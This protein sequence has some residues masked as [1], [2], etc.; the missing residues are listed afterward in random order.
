MEQPKHEIADILRG[1]FHRLGHLSKRTRQ[2]VHNIIACRTEI[3][4]GH[5]YECDDPDC[6][7]S[8]H[9]YNSC[10]DRHCP[11][12]QYAARQEW[13]KARMSEVLP[14]PY[15]HFV[16]TLPHVFNILILTNKVVI[17]NLFFKTASNVVKQL[18]A[19]EYE[20]AKAGFIA[21]LHTWG[22]NL[23]LHPHIHMVIPGGGLADDGT[24]WVKCRSGKTSK[25]E[26]FLPVVT[27]SSM[28]RAQFVEGLKELFYKGK[29]TFLAV[30][31]CID[32]PGA[33]QDLLD[34]SFKTPW[35]V[36]AKHPFATPLAVL[37]YLGNYTHRIA[38]SNRRIVAIES[39]SVVFSYKD[40]RAGKKGKK[41]HDMKVM[42]L[43]IVEFMRRF[44][45]HVVPRGFSRIRY[46]GF[47]S[48]GGKTKALAK[49]RELLA[50]DKNTVKAATSLVKALEECNKDGPVHSDICPKCNRGKMVAVHKLSPVRPTY[51]LPVSDS[52]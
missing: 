13:V 10:G 17:Y 12:C 21:V 38:F 36:Y 46:Y 29:L 6:D 26:Y 24:K 31:A 51:M 28:F 35:V 19:T 40:Y 20:G 2:V 14:V 39:D 48:A 34:K 37:R 30:N 32:S 44:L 1:H 9:S 11:K 42:S 43:S 7:N 47:L 18:F 25:K 45:M 52:S 33:F 41:S 49:A 3:M 22:Q 16:F 15:F 50:A 5:L 27:L 23:S 4:G 8:D